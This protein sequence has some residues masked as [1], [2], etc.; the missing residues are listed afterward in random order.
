MCA[1]MFTALCAV[2]GRVCIARV[3]AYPISSIYICLDYS[4]LF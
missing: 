3:T 1:Y 4:D 2:H